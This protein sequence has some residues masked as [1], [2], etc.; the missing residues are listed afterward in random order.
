MWGKDFIDASCC[1]L[2]K[3]KG[4]YTE[5]DELQWWFG[6]LGEVRIVKR[7]HIATFL[8]DADFYTGNITLWFDGGFCSVMNET[9]T[10]EPT[11]EDAKWYTLECD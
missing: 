10:D 8:S 1:S 5:Y 6:D 4:E 11:L 7:V 3:N 2:T 9:Y